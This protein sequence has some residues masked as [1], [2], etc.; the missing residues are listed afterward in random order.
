MVPLGGWRWIAAV[1]GDR[2]TTALLLCQLSVA[3]V[4]SEAGP[5]VSLPLPENT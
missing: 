3:P 5:S 2:I 4:A 1:P